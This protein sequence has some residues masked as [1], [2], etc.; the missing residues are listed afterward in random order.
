MKKTLLVFAMLVVLAA[1]AFASGQNESGSTATAQQPQTVRYS[2]WGNP[3]A[4]GVEDDIIKAFEAANPAI[5]VEP[6]VSGYND[7]HTK[8]LTMIAGG[9]APDVMRV[10]SYFFGD[11]LQANALREID[12]LIQRDHINM[13]AY[14]PEGVSENSHNGKIYGLP[15]GTAPLYMMLNLKMFHD[16]G[17]ALPPMNWN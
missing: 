11:F 13:K 8:L 17:V 1:V 6:V 14:Y 7:Y 12:D 10:D 15:W 16:A 9:A 2:F 3:D 5:K 4:I